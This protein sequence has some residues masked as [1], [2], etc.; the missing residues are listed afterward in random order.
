MIGA[1]EVSDLGAD[2]AGAR[3][4]RSGVGARTKPEAD[5]GEEEIGPATEDPLAGTN[6]DEPA[7]VV[8]L[9]TLAVDVGCPPR[10]RVVV[11][12]AAVAEISPVSIEVVVTTLRGDPF[13][14]H[15]PRGRVDLGAQDE[16]GWLAQEQGV[17]VEHDENVV[18]SGPLDVSRGGYTIRRSILRTIDVENAVIVDDLQSVERSPPPRRDRVPR[19][20]RQCVDRTVSKPPRVPPN[21]VEEQEGLALEQASLDAGDEAQVR[22]LGHVAKIISKGGRRY[23]NYDLEPAV[24][25]LFSSACARP[26]ICPIPA[27]RSPCCERRPARYD[28]TRS[29][30]LLAAKRFDGDRSTVEVAKLKRNV[31]AEIRVASIP[32]DW[33]PPVPGVFVK[34]TMNNLADLG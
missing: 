17:A 7:V 3:P 34:N 5:R 27:Y 22:R 12:A 19:T 4:E 30:D 23:G 8:R 20:R 6:D 32:G 24:D 16:L 26:G 9:D 25:S 18:A 21:A 14:V 2:P 15:G 33:I 1:P 28:D 11:D 31:E 10:D 13:E 29:T